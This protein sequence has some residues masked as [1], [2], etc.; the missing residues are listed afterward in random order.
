MSFPARVPEEAR[1]LFAALLDAPDP[2]FV[3]DRHNHI[4][5]W[6]RRAEGLLGYSAEEAVGLSCA[7]LLHGSDMYGNRYCAE[8]CPVTQMGVRSEPIRHFGMGG[9]G[10]YQAYRRMLRE[11]RS[12]HAAE[13]L[14]LYIWGDD[15]TRSLLR[16][17]HA[18]TYRSW[19]PQGGRA[20]HGNFWPNLE[21][22]LQTGSFVEKDNLLATRESLYQMTDP[23]RMVDLLKD[24]LALRA[25]AGLSIFWKSPM[26]PLRFDFSQV[27]AKQPYDKTET[28][29]FSTST[30]F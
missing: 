26:G 21:M 28:F 24:D 19:D 3:T 16:C 17:R 20:F 29:R 23:Q 8:T 25:T 13:Y 12:A 14:I 11:E 22:D 15:H 18:M 9:Y 6:N 10:V 1:P 7:A 2:A 4:V 27:L 5:F 30:R